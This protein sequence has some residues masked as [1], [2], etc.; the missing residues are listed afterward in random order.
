MTRRFAFNSD[1][2]R[3]DTIRTAEAFHVRPY[4]LDVFSGV[5]S[6]FLPTDEMTEEGSK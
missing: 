4:S 3:R 1:T 6:G 5:Q 2:S